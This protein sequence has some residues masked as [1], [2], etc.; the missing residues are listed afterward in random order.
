MMMSNS[1]LCLIGFG[2]AG[3]EIAG[4]LGAWRDASTAP[5]PTITAFDIKSTQPDSAQLMRRRMDAVG[6]ECASDLAMAMAG[7]QAVISVVT[8]DR[9]HEAAVMAAQHIEA[10][11]LFLDM[12]SCAPGTKQKSADVIEQAGGRY[13]DV[14][15]MA[16]ITTAGHRTT[17]LAASTHGEAAVALFTALDMKVSLVGDAPGRASTIKMLRSVMIKGIEALTAECFQAACRAG[18]AD[19]VAASLD[20]S[21]PDEGWAERASYNMERMTTHGLRRAAEMREVVVTLAELGVVSGMSAATAARQ[22]AF[23]AAGLDLTNVRGLAARMAA[24]EAGFAL[25]E[26]EA[27]NDP[28]AA[29]KTAQ[30]TID[31]GQ[32]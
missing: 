21:E 24:I 13:V 3:G 12:N 11:T 28:G 17:M 18:V 23:G 20:A 8:A 19:E 16:P 31:E 15:V 25:G 27:S 10:G 6:V 1:R 2:E 5:L 7:A 32:D 4:S 22:D 30:K 14:A 26:P 9:A 29:D